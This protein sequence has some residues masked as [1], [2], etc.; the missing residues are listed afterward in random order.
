MEEPDDEEIEVGELD[1]LIARYGRPAAI[2]AESGNDFTSNAAVG[3]A[4]AARLHYIL[5][6]NPSENGFVESFN[7]RMRDELL[8]ETVFFWLAHEGRVE[9]F[10]LFKRFRSFCLFSAAQLSGELVRPRW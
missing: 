6:G 4:A 8:N 3:W 5:L 1:D 9:V 10:R 7:G 2:V